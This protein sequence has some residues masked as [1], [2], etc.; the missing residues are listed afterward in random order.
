MPERP[1]HYVHGTDPEEQARLTRLNDIL[2]AGTLR[3]LA[4]A[5]GE[6]VLDV[7]AG[8]GQLSRAMARATG[9]R[10]VAVERSPEQR[11]EALR[12]ARAAGEEG[13]V[14]LRAG[15]A[16]ELPLTRAEWGSFDVAHTRF[17][18]EH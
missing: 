14:E 7:G 3:E 18:L 13:L 12:Q 2:N 9:S 4:L 6:R 5:G 17:L 11:A 10:V 1:A 15:D 16:R 8:L